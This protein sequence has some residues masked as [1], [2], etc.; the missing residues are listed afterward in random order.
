[1]TVS[2]RIH[3][4]LAALAAGLLI[5]AT[6][7]EAPSI[8]LPDLGG[9]S[10]TTATFPTKGGTLM[11]PPR[12]LIPIVERHASRFR[13]TAPQV[14]GVI[15]QESAFNAKAVSH[16]GALGLMQLMP[17]TIDDLNARGA[18]IRDPFDPDQNV[19]GGTRY[20]RWL[21]DE[22]A[23]VQPRYRWAYTLAAYN[24]GIGRLKRAMD[25]VGGPDASYHAVAPLLPKE[26]QGYVPAVLR[27]QERYRGQWQ[28]LKTAPSM[29]TTAKPATNRL[30]AKPATPAR[31]A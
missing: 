17:A 10:K 5:G 29:R 15:A 22:L 12:T 4:R 1:M 18:S 30:K 27:H 21:Y 6:G 8:I 14:Y 3:L 20:L 11:I 16:A 13:L 24:G 28:T 19:G 2:E 31:K 26:T 9:P 7:C 25:K 23:G